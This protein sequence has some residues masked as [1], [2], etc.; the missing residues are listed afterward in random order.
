[1]PNLLPQP[2]FADAGFIV[3]LLVLIFTVV[4]WLVNI[5]NAQNQP[6]PPPQKRPPRPPRPKRERVQNEID[7]FLKE[8]RG[9]TVIDEDDVVLESVP[10]TT[11]QRP[12]LEAQSEEEGSRS[13]L[14]KMAPHLE[15]HVGEHL[16]SHH[17]E[18]HVGEPQPKRESPD[19]RATGEMLAIQGKTAKS[20]PLPIAG[21]LKNREG[22]RQAI[23][24]NEIL[25]KPKA[26]RDE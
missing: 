18:S 4:G 13:R 20:T 8:V 10:Q 3:G 7:I 17:L 23:M 9:D 26:L 5:A 6:P 16:A 12:G 11:R 15:S 14:G 19:P 24:V 1:M 2:L 22:I 25:S 21:L